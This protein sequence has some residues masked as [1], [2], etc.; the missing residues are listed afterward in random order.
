MQKTKRKNSGASDQ[1]K[2]KRRCADQTEDDVYSDKSVFCEML[3]KAGFILTNGKKNNEI[4]VDQAVLQRSLNLALKRRNSYPDVLEDFLQGFQDYIENVSRFYKS[5]MPTLT[6]VECES[7]RSSTQNSLVR[8]LLGMDIIQPKLVT[9]LLE[10]L[11]E[12]VG[13][14][15]N[16]FEEGEKVF[17]P[18]L[19]LSQFRWLDR[20][21]CSKDLT[22]KL[23]E[24]IEVTSFDVQ[25]EI[26]SCLPEIVEDSEHSD[27]AKTLRDILLQGNQ[28]TVPILDA[29]SNLALKPD[30]L[31]EVRG[32][33]MQT[34]DSVEMKDLPV[35]VKFLLQTATSQDAL[36]VVSEIRANLSFKSSNTQKKGTRPGSESD[37]TKDNEALTLDAI[38]A[39]IRFQKSI[40]EAWIKAIDSLKSPADHKVIDIFVLLILH[41]TNRRKPVESL[42][43]NKIRTSAFTEVLLHAAFESHGQIL[44]DYF[45]SILSIAEVL[46]RSP[47]P[48]I[49]YFACAMYKQAFSTF[50]TFCQQEIVGNL[51]THIGS[52]FES[53]IDSSLDIL[54]DL[55]QNHLASMAPFSIFVKGVLDYLDNL[56]VIQIR[57]LYGM[58]S[59]LAFH[60]PQDGGLVQDDLHMVIRK[61]LSSDNPKYKKMGVIGA[62]MVC[63]SIAFTGNQ[64]DET[65]PSDLS[66]QVISL[67]QLVRTSSS[68]MP[69]AAALFMDE[70]SAIVGLGQKESEVETWIADNVIADFQDDYVVDIE[71]DKLT[72]TSAVPLAVLYGLNDEQDSTIAIDLLPL[73][74]KTRSNKSNNDL[75]R[76][77][78]DPLCLC[79]HFRLV[80]MC[81][82]H[83][84]DGNLE[85]I[86]ALLGCPLYTVKEDAIAKFESLSDK[87]GEMLCCTLFHNLNWFRRIINCFAT[88]TDPEMKGKVI[89]RLQ[90]I[91]DL[92]KKL[93]KC[94]AATQQFQPPPANFD[95]EDQM[96]K[97]SSDTAEVKKKGRKSGKKKAKGKEEKENVDDSDE[98]SRDSTQMDTDK[99]SPKESQNAV[100]SDN[101]EEICISLG[102]YRQYFRELDIGVFTVLNTGLISCAALDSDLNTKAVTSLQISPPQLEFLLD[103]LSQKLNHSLIA[104]ASKRRTFLKVKGNKNAGFHHLDQLSRDEIAGKAVQLLPALCNHL[105]ATSAF[106]QTMINDNDGLIDGPGYDGDDAVLMTSCFHLLLQSLTSLFSWNGF[107]VTENQ[108]LLKE[109]LC[110]LVGRIK[111]LGSTQ[112]SFQDL[113]SIVFQYLENFAATVPNI[114]TAVTL[115]KL[116][117]ALTAKVD[118]QKLS[119][120]LGGHAETFLKREW[121]GADGEKEKGAKHNDSLQSI[122]KT[123]LTYSDDPLVAAETITTKG[124]SELIE[125][126]KKGCSNTF[127]SLNRW[128]FPVFFRVVFS[129]L[130]TYIK[131]MQPV[132]SSDSREVKVDVLIRWNIAVRIL[133]ILVNLIKTFDGRSIVGAALKNGR[134]F[135]DVFLRNGMPVLD[136]M[137]RTNREEVQS[138]LK[139]FQLSTRTLHHLSSHSKIIR[140]VSLTNQV[141][142][143]KRAL[144]QFV[145]RV[146]AM[147]TVNNCL[148]A[149]WLGNLKNRDLQG[150]E[151]LS[152][153]SEVSENGDKSD[154]EEE[155]VP[156]DEDSEVEMDNVSEAG[157]E[158]TDQSD[159]S[160]D[161]SCS[162]V[163]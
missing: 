121:I 13:D 134:L 17:L 56:S 93:M 139:N 23:L 30:L 119:S 131:S 58:L 73:V 113:V 103:D 59:Q 149:F 138:L 129:E 66:K 10:K 142:L 116:L 27:V 11:P 77:I 102:N 133:H 155:E 106:F 162:D 47:E 157:Q 117:G 62:I 95:L 118:N 136:K 115:I 55:V 60:N 146:K 37:V 63:K 4:G 3:N 125:S 12:F 26:I 43:R 72:S 48:G 46:L 79:P 159:E 108:P 80:Q 107:L 69:V 16:I 57:K 8:I 82:R 50:D 24:I 81:E 76:K 67:L 65:L 98:A 51:V 144:E 9:L 83:Q 147:L 39:G 19:L 127:A 137:F 97:V 126:D 22:V 105:E 88:Q 140:D 49:L 110:I 161:Q 15:D 135:V 123:Y 25:R 64:S 53:E 78:P 120:K 89:M 34:L 61:Q 128:S 96:L 71:E 1:S 154:N 130:I 124:F 54:V 38:K 92:Q 14:D 45:P 148:E 32:S 44:R 6:S 21:I 28:L 75:N 141:P 122:I 90:N 36:E 109:A 29:L 114:S 158:K 68:R 156:D 35:V 7:A 100:K 42:F 85:G 87:A 40:A 86:D 70:L 91:T 74:I 160:D 33:V 143:L 132:K 41:S 152:Q 99:G 163:F 112:V 150:D 145:Y 153:V 94:L 31:T 2:R 101:K 84:Q 151:I 5:L 52:G 20:I 18:R 104:S 111:T